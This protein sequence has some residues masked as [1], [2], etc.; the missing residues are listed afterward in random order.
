MTTKKRNGSTKGAAEITQLAGGVTK[1]KKKVFF[2]GVKH[3]SKLRRE[4]HAAG[5]ELTNASRCTQQQML[6]RTLQYLGPR[7]LNTP[8]GVGLGF[9]RIATRIQELE[10][11]GW[12]IASMRENLVG[13]DGLAHRGIARYVL[14]GRHADAISPQG[15]LDLGAAC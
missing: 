7:G 13:E 15:S 10:A 9:Y 11:H 3:T 12:H 6:L 5:L 1:A 14:L 2:C 4:L 8:E